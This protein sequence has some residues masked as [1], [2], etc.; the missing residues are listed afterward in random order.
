[1]IENVA[2]GRSIRNGFVTYNED[3][4]RWTR[5]NFNDYLKEIASYFGYNTVHITSGTQSRSAGY[6]VGYGYDFDRVMTV[7]TGIQYSRVYNRYGSA[8][9]SLGAYRANN[10]DMSRKTSWSNPPSTDH[11]DEPAYMYRVNAYG[12]ENGLLSGYVVTSVSS[13]LISFGVLSVASLVMMRLRKK[14][15]K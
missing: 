1:M 5:E 4:T 15:F 9:V 6:V 13:P 11:F 2:Q 10:G 12:K 8:Q 3:R 14:K 7:E